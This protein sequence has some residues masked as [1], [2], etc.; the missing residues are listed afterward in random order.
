M[1]TRIILSLSIIFIVFCAVC[2][3]IAATGVLTELANRNEDFSIVWAVLAGILSL[4]AFFYGAFY[5]YSPIYNT[6]ADQISLIGNKHLAF[7]LP[8]KNSIWKHYKGG[9]YKVMHIANKYSKAFDRYPT[10]VVY[11]STS[12]HVVYSKTIAA[13]SKTMTHMQGSPL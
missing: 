1:I 5:L 12:T 9:Y 4:V 3:P 7:N 10:T 13:W 2:S 6:V 8:E 11:Q